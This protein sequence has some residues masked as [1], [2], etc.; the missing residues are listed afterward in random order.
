MRRRRGEKKTGGS[1]KKIRQRG[2]AKETR[3]RRNK[4]TSVSCFLVS[5][6]ASSS[7]TT[8]PHERKTKKKIDVTT[9]TEK[10]RVW[11]AQENQKGKKQKQ[12]LGSF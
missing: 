1:D 11:V 3:E 8:T 10:K 9:I 4:T 12:E 5:P 2:R 6:H 7:D